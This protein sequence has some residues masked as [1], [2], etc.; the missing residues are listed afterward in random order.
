MSALLTKGEFFLYGARCLSHSVVAHVL[1]ENVATRGFLADVP[2]II[3]VLW[4]D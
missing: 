4:S 2:D 3:P 1:P